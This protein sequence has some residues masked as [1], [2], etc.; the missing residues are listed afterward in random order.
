MKVFGLDPGVEFGIAVYIDGR[1][2]ELRTGDIS[3]ATHSHLDADLLVYE[4]ARQ[5]STVFLGG[6][7]KLSVAQKLK[8]AQDVGGIKMQC[9]FIEFFRL[10]ANMPLIGVSPRNKGKKLNAEQFKAITGWSKP[11][12]QHTRDAAIVAWPYRN[13]AR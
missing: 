5:Q 2:T 10:R 4:D 12:N 8:I 1:L 13:G 6:S 9:A 7:S 3:E 11:S